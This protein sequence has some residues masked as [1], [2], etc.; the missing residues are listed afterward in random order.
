MD[1]AQII[2]TEHIIRDRAD[3]IAE[4]QAAGGLG[5]ATL[6]LESRQ[7]EH[8]VHIMTSTYAILV[9]D[10]YTN[11]CITLYL[12]NQKQRYVFE[13]YGHRFNRAE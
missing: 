4:I 1:F 2:I 12:A 5:K 7:E 8:I 3:R 9:V 10:K 6:W 11:T 13:K